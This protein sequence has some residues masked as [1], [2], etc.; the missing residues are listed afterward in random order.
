MLITFGFK[1][2]AA[3]LFMS[4]AGTRAGLA[5]IALMICG[6]AFIYHVPAPDYLL[7]IHPYLP[8]GIKVITGLIFIVC[9]DMMRD[10]NG[11]EDDN[12]KPFLIVLVIGLVFLFGLL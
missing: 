9:G 2:I 7:A 6:I 8:A 1:V 11:P 4:L 12:Y 5:F 3:I 10:V